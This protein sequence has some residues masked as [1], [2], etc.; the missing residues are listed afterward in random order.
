MQNPHSKF[1]NHASASFR[2]TVIVYVIFITIKTAISNLYCTMLPSVVHM[3]FAKQ[4]LKIGRQLFLER[5]YFV[6]EL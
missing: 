5:P 4:I 1:D 2:A 3:K 6:I